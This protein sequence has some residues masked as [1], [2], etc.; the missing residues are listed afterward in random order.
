MT[1]QIQLA[2]RHPENI[3]PSSKIA[4]QVALHIQELICPDPGSAFA[5]MIELGW[6]PEIEEMVE[7]AASHFRRYEGLKG[8]GR[9]S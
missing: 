2:L 8:G 5:T 3:G 1:C 4:R 7:E 9:V 6:H